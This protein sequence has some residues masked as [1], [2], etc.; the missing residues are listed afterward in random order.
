MDFARRLLAEAGGRN[1]LWNPVL[2][3]ALDCPPRA[4]ASKIKAA[5]SLNGMNGIGAGRKSTRES[6]R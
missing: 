1:D 5:V 4:A 3:E 2:F 6:L